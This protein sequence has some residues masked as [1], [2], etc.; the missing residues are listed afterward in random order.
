MAG[1]QVYLR[2]SSMVVMPAST[3]ARPSSRMPRSILVFPL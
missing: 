1:G 2:T 3:L